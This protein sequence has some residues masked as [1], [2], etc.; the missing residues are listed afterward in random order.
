MILGD[1]DI[2]RILS[3]IKVGVVCL[4]KEFVI[5]DFISEDEF[6]YLKVYI[7]GF[8]EC[9]IIKLLVNIKEGEKLWL[10]GI[11]GIIEVLVI[12]NVYKKMGYIL[13]FLGGY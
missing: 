5:I 10:V 13:I 3:S 11:V 12:I 1:S 7:R 8:L 9:L 6:V 4:I 2:V